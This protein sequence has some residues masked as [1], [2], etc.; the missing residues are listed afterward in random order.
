M[1]K[2]IH[3]ER[4]DVM[5]QEELVYHW[6]QPWHGRRFRICARVVDDRQIVIFARQRG[7]K[8]FKRAG[9]TFLPSAVVLDSPLEIS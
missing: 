5:S 4:A 3:P 6:S 2:S 7:V 9:A 8:P 1:A